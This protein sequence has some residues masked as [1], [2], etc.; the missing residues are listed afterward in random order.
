VKTSTVSSELRVW[1]DAV[2]MLALASLAVIM[3]QTFLNL[4]LN[5]IFLFFSIFTPLALAVIIYIY[6]RLRRPTPPAQP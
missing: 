1:R 6:L 2:I 5:P 3:L 4:Q